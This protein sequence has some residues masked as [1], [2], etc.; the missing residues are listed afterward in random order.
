[1]S[2]TANTVTLSG[3]VFSIH[4]PSTATVLSI[5]NVVGRVG[6]RAEKLAASVMSNP[7]SRAVVFGLLAAMTVDD[8]TKFGIAV[9]QVD[10]KD[11]ESCKFIEANLRVAPLVQAFLLNVSLSTDLAEALRSFFA[12]TT[13]L[14][15]VV[16]RL[17]P[18]RTEGGPG[19]DGQTPAQYQMSLEPAPSL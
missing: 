2:E 1:M 5:L 16:N 15:G 7:S 4:E 14:T 8:L 3:R 9:L 18:D 17:M 12:G 11:A 10:G 19:A 13:I 6:M